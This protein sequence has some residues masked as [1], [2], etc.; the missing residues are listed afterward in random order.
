MKKIV[1]AGAVMAVA[2]GAALHRRRRWRSQGNCLLAMPWISWWALGRGRRERKGINRRQ[3]DQQSETAAAA[4]GA[5]SMLRT[6]PRCG[7]RRWWSEY[8]AK[9]PFVKQKSRPDAGFFY[10][11]PSHVTDCGV[12]AR[13]PLQANEFTK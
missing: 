12:Y 3:A 4:F 6:R 11:L 10:A 9:I 7:T 8:Q 2:C 5:P 1:I 13:M